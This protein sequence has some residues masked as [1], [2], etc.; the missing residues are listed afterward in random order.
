[1][2][3]RPCSH[4][5]SRENKRNGNQIIAEVLTWKVEMH[6]RVKYLHTFGCFVSWL[7]LGSIK[8]CFLLFLSLHSSFAPIFLQ[9][10]HQCK[11]LLFRT[12]GNVAIVPYTLYG[13]C[14]CCALSFWAGI[15]HDLLLNLK[16]F[17]FLYPAAVMLFLFIAF[18]LLTCNKS[19]KPILLNLP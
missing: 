6:H 9:F 4:Q 1:M 8:R 19:S 17:W 5:F 14:Y 2:S 16:E 11:V 18:L 15:E 10:P 3:N 13:I 12:K 7:H